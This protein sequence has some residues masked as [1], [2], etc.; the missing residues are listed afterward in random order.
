MG[1]SPVL[2]V[3]KDVMHISDIL[4]DESLVQ[5]W[6]AITK[7]T[8]GSLSRGN[9]LLSK[10]FRQFFQPVAN[11]VCIININAHQPKVP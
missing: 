4:L 10:T 3:Q 9:W 5:S 8:R 7:F 6:L 2:P 1:R 11:V